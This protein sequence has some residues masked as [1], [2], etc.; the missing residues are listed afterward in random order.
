MPAAA[1]AFVFVASA[2]T[3]P[4]LK[5]YGVTPSPM[6]QAVGALA[7]RATSEHAVVSG[8]F[9]FERYLPLLPDRLERLPLMHAKEWQSLTEYWTGGRRDPVLFLREAHR[10][11]SGCQLYTRSP[12]SRTVRTIP[13]SGSE[14]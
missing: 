2:A 8:H 7:T 12:R 9:A 5:A 1:V 13:K 11:T 4:A 3:L 10:T 14:R 6:M